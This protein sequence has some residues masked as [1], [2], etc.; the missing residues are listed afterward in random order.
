GDDASGAGQRRAGD[1]DRGDGGAKGGV[2]DYFTLHCVAGG[3]SFVACNEL[4]RETNPPFWQSQPLSGQSVGGAAHHFVP[5]LHRE[6]PLFHPQDRVSALLGRLSL[7]Y[8][9]AAHPGRLAAPTLPLPLTRGG[10][11][12]CART[13]CC[14][15]AY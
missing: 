8:K 14:G 7:R 15:R 3:G 13:R 1:A 4:Q 2:T 12:P 11:P 5:T 9:P 6:R 10:P